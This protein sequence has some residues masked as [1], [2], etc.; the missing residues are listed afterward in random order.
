MSSGYR[1]APALGARLLGLALVVVAALLLALTLLAAVLA[2]PATT[3]LVPGLVA[4]LVVVAAGVAVRRVPVLALDDTGYRVRWVRGAGVRRAAWRDV[5][6]AVTASPSGIDCVVLRLRAG[7]TTS[8][9][10]TAV[11]ADRDALVTEIRRHLSEGEGLR[12]L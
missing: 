5:A 11:A 9:P 2:W 12:P 8:I 1:L 4:V 6:D 3:V 10:V 7:G